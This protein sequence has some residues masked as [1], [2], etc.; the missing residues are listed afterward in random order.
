MAFSETQT[1]NDPVTFQLT[2][3]ATFSA[4]ATTT[5]IVHAAQA[6]GTV[7]YLNVSCN[8]EQNVLCINVGPT[9]FITIL[10]NYS[11]AAFWPPDRIITLRMNVIQP[12]SFS[13]SIASSSIVTLFTLH[14]DLQ[15]NF[16]PNIVSGGSF[17]GSSFLS[18]SA[19]L[20]MIQTA[21]ASVSISG[22]TDGL[23]VSL[24]PTVFPPFPGQLETSTCIDLDSSTSTC[25]T[26]PAVVK[27]VYLDVETFS[28][29]PGPPFHFNFV[30]WLWG[31]IAVGLCCCLSLAAIGSRDTAEVCKNCATECTDT[32]VPWCQTCFL[33]CCCGDVCGNYRDKQIMEENLEKAR[34]RYRRLQA[35]RA[36]GCC[37]CNCG[38]GKLE[39]GE[40]S[41]CG[42]LCGCCDYLA[43]KR[44]GVGL[45]FEP[46]C[47]KCRKKC[48]K[49]NPY[50]NHQR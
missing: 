35:V 14:H 4:P 20:D 8:G 17:T 39:P 31:V 30:P 34:K 50:G 19:P 42:K 45:T 1:L 5:F 44:S 37:Y 26:N 32:C 49:G 12:T 28:S 7:Q 23:Q 29:I 43:R 2:D 13:F 46:E 15:G 22:N 33:C 27:A 16:N 41:N 38:C 40:Y 11:D 3:L 10:V 48:C 36:C 25:S 21:V 9:Y 6:V 18:M 47:D 24:I